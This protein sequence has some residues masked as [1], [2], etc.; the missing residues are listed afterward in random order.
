M[1]EAIE[2]AIHILRTAEVRMETEGTPPWLMAPERYAEKLA[3][4]ATLS[5]ARMYLVHQLAT[6]PEYKQE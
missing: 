4:K 1:R 3:A 2:R 5:R 6:K